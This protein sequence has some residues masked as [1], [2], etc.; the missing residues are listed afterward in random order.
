MPIPTQAANTFA[1]DPLIEEAVREAGVGDPSVLDTPGLYALDDA[2]AACSESLNFIGRARARKM[3]LETLVKR[4]RL[5][6]HLA[7]E[8]SIRELPLHSPI[9]LVAPFRTGTTLLHR[10]LAL[11]PAHRTPRLWEALQAPPAEP[12]YRGD[13]R[14]FELDYR[15]EIAR[16]YMQT[17]ARM[18]G[19]IDSIHPSGAD[20]PEECF[21]LLETSLLSHSF[22]FYAPVTDYLAWLNERSDDDWIES[23]ALYADQ[24]RLLQWW[25]PGE[26]WVL[27]TPFHMWAVDALRANLPDAVVVQQHRSP[28]SCVA[29]FCSLTAVV[30]KPLLSEIDLQ[31]IGRMSMD[32]LR[33]ALA[34]NVAARQ[35]LGPAR[36]VD[37][38]YAD[39]MADPIACVRRVYETAGLEFAAPV[40]VRMRDWLASQ[41]KSREGSRHEYAIADYGIDRD[42]VEEAFRGY[43]SYNTG[44][45]G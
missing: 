13:P 8:P 41:S 23:Y 27:K 22:M 30:Y 25:Y 19:G 15:V 20:L 17:R 42:E 45:G 3:L 7:T 14:Y 29:S 40:E 10:L 16:R 9:V 24:L 32:Y 36:F 31:A 4:L 34:R 43:S 18:S 37:I 33:A 5:A 11:D 28:E 44:A 6:H 12:A 39:L 38:D 35:R 1:V 26:R 2:L 21:G